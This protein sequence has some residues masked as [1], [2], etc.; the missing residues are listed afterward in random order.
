MPARRTLLLLLFPVFLLLWSACSRDE[1][2]T[3]VAE[4]PSTVEPAATPAV[5]QLTRIRD[6][7][8][9]PLRGA[10]A[11]Y[12]LYQG[13]AYQIEIP[14]D[15]NGGLVIYAHGYRGEGGE[16]SVSDPP[17]RRHLI[18]NGYAWAASSFRMNGYRP[19]IGMEDT[20]ALKSLFIEKY[21]EPRWTILEGSSMGGHV[22][23]SSLELHPDAYQGGLAE[24]AAIG[25]GQMDYLAAFAAA[26]EYISGVQLFNATDAQSFIRRVFQEWLPAV[27]FAQTP[28]D[29]GRALQSVGKYL[30]GGELPFWRE[31]FAARMTQAANLLLLADPNVQLSPAG[32]ATSTRDVRYRIDP[33]LGFTAEEINSNVRR[34][35]PQPGARSA[36]ENAVFAELTGRIT[37]PVL[38]LHTTGDAFVPFM[39]EQEY[40]RTTIEAGTD[41]LLVQR[42]IRRPS[43]CEFETAELTRAFDD[44]VA[45]IEDGDKPEGDDI[46]APDLSTLGLRW[47]TPL[48]PND[49][50]QP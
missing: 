23:F 30:M 18:A 15:W 14:E 29:K 48:L 10:R 11:D 8:F 4:A 25:V 49:P 41:D 36:A 39:L 46:L 50:A 9:R 33:G 19:D 17:I 40:R 21:G 2:E 27:G 1:P 24:C 22:L 38:S 34:I 47:T 45:W 44:L 31:G 26:A 43:H 16:P 28:T 3:P 37:V 12:G 6:P 13:G 35:E 7:R 5:G 42:G 32:R 20:L